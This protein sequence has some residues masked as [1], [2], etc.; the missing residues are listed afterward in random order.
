MPSNYTDPV[1]TN[2]AD[3]DMETPEDEKEQER[4]SLVYLKALRESAKA[5]TKKYMG[6][7]ENAWGYAI[8]EK[9][10]P[11]PRNTAAKKANQHLS[12]TV[13]NSMYAMMDHKVAFVTDAEPRVIMKVL[14][15]ISEGDRRKLESVLESELD[16]LDWS[17]D[18]E[19]AAWDAE[20]GSIGLTMFYLEKNEL[21]GEAEICTRSVDPSKVYVNRQAD[22]KGIKGKRLRHMVFEEDL[23]LAEIRRMWPDQGWRV[24]AKSTKAV[25]STEDD[26][27]YVE[28]TD[29]EI[30]E[31]PGN[32]FV[33]TKE[34][35]VVDQSATVTWAWERWP[36]TRAIWEEQKNE[37]QENGYY[38]PTCDTNYI[39]DDPTC[40]DCQGEMEPVE[41]PP[42]ASAK[43]R[44]VQKVHPFGRCLIGIPEQ[45][46]M[47]FEGDNELPLERV[48]PFAMDACYK[49]ARC[50][51]GMGDYHMLKSNSQALDQNIG[52]LRD[53][54]R[55]NAHPVF[56]YPKTAE[57]YQTRGNAPGTQIGVDDE[58]CGMARNIPG[59]G[60]DYQGFREAENAL[61]RDGEQIT[62]VDEIL[63]GGSAGPESGE[64][65]KARQVARGKRIAARLSKH[66]SYRTDYAAI[67]WELMTK[68][69]TTPRTFT[70]RGPANELQA[71]TLTLSE[72]P[73]KDVVVHV[74][75]D[76][77]KVET[78][79]LMGQNLGQFITSGALFDEKLVPFMD[80]I[81]SGFGVPPSRA[82]VIQS[83]LNEFHQAQA[84]AP[85][86][87]PQ[88]PSKVLVAM[89]DIL[90]VAPTFVSYEQIQ[91]GLAAAGIR[92]APQDHPLIAQLQDALNKTQGHE[93]APLPQALPPMAPPG[94]EPQMEGVTQ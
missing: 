33:V 94:P 46:I 27:D 72:L 14:Q 25:N 8:G 36:E 59:S 66:N 79:R 19:A 83:K 80:D 67:V 2:G 17:S 12:R 48:F 41:V 22:D 75:A 29:D 82:E 39:A 28:K 47:L 15:T 23:S 5:H 70:V 61:R 64:A 11:S 30:V 4:K 68:V 90:K 43:R 73:Y 7:F 89:A 86:P 84:Q 81:L 50:F 88:D 49:K 58:V 77:D 26:F 65:I 57:E 92:P 60:F 52:L 87:G 62:G 13:R 78:D 51:Y 10:F 44:F 9:R 6:D 37:T 18:G 93:T 55:Y 69:Y 16:R 32:E 21:T 3:P 85:P 35:K 34:G 40:P 56:E 53:H 76:P 24:K 1:M 54:L 38:C 74:T 91:E 42:G 20:I 71:I 31:M 63:T 45:G